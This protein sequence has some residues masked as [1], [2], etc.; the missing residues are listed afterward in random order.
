MKCSNRGVATLMPSTADRDGDGRCDDGIAIKQRCSK[1]ACAHDQYRTS[2]C[3]VGQ[4]VGQRGQ[5]Q[6]ATFA[7]IVVLQHN[8]HVL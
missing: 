6:H 5:C 1:Y 3:V 8:P 4:P 7:V 2:W